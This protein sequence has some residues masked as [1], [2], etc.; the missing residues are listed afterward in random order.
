MAEFAHGQAPRREPIERR[1]WPRTV[2]KSE[3][4]IRLEL[5][6]R[7]HLLDISYTGALLASESRLPVCTRGQVRTE[8]AALPF[9]ADVIVKRHH[10][11]KGAADALLGTQF[12]SMDDR[13]RQHL[14]Q[15]LQRVKD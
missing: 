14:D 6:D 8:L 1:R 9:S 10:G 7:V 3:P 12:G 2:L 5:R 15:F 4:L 13:S 11:K